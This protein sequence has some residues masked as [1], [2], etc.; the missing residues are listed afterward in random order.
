EALAGADRRLPA[1]GFDA[2]WLDDGDLAF[3]HQHELVHR[4]GPGLRRHGRA[5]PHPGGE[6]ELL[7]L[8][9]A[10]AALHRRAGDQL[11]GGDVL[12]A[13]QAPACGTV[14]LEMNDL[15]RAHETCSWMKREIQ[16]TWRTCPVS[17]PS[18]DFT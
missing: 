7:H 11:V 14:R 3:Q 9:I 17:R 13:L 15:G 16:R 4:I 2:T 6:S 5:V 18:T 12:Q 10:V 8:E 1:A